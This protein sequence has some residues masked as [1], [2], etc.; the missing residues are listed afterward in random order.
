[1]EYLEAPSISD[2]YT[3]FKACRY[4]TM[5]TPDVFFS[6][7]TYLNRQAFLGTG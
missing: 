3:A 7:I 4:K 2:A 6:S 5:Q 1:M